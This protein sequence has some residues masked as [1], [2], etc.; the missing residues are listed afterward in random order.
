MKNPQ[1]NEYD[2]EKISKKEE[3]MK[4][5]AEELGYDEHTKGKEGKNFNIYEYE[6]LKAKMKKVTD[7]N[8]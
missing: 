6:L 2:P 8:I 1:V 7:L 5:V 4:K 3:L